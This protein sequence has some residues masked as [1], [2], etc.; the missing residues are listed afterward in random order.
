MDI[1]EAWRVLVPVSVVVALGVLLAVVGH[2]WDRMD[3]NVAPGPRPAPAPGPGPGQG[4]ACA[5]AS[6]THVTP[7]PHS[8]VSVSSPIEDKEEVEDK[9]EEVI[10]HTLWVA[11][12]RMLSPSF[13]RSSE[14]VSEGVGKGVWNKYWGVMKLFHPY[15]NVY[16]RYIEQYPRPLRVMSLMIRVLLV[17]TIQAVIFTNNSLCNHST[18]QID[19]ESQWLSSWI[20]TSSICYWDESGASGSDHCGL[21]N[22]G[23]GFQLALKIALF[24]IVLSIPAQV[25]VNWMAIYV[26]AAD[27]TSL[28]V[29]VS[30]TIADDTD[31]YIKMEMKQCPLSKRSARK[32]KLDLMEKKATS[33]FGCSVLN[34]VEIFQQA[35]NGYTRTKNLSEFRKI[36]GMLCLYCD[37]I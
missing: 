36:N 1:V 25:F 15:L 12:E 27:A 2:S 35:F 4:T 18:T 30:T 3:S 21:M 31:E 6:V 34:E 23:G 7:S 37:E 29:Q 20:K 13:T 10:M 26:L 17:L 14:C 22:I 5:T 24:S 33:L 16:T 28:A 11:I 8:V 19:C 9:E 32:R